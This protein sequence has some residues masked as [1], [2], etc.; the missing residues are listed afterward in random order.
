MCEQKDPKILRKILEPKKR[1]EWMYHDDV[2]GHP[3]DL[4]LKKKLFVFPNF[5]L[6]NVFGKKTHFT[7]IKPFIFKSII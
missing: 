6:M 4:N 3:F 5:D 2:N 7:T 1:K